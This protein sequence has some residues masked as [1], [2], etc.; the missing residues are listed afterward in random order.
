MA[1]AGPLALTIVLG[2][3]TPARAADAA[4]EEASRAARDQGVHYLRIKRY[5][6][7]L[8]RLEEAARLPGGAGDYQTQYSLAMAAYKLLVLEKAFPAARRAVELAEGARAEKASQRLLQRMDDFFGGVTLTQAPDQV[9]QVEKGLV[10]LEDTGGLINKEK[11]ESFARIR[12]RFKATPVELPLTIYLPFGKYTANL[13]P[14]ETKNGE[15]AD[16]V[17]FLYVP[18]NEGGISP[19]WYIGGGVAAAAIATTATVL[20]MDTD[21]PERQVQ[22]R[23]VQLTTPGE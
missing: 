21:P 2:A 12:D 10:H 6:L 16:A 22:I 4:E 3:A 20:L 13:A 8:G 23:S 11:K 15:T 17:M 18:D 7:A 19:W 14:F 1:G 9:G 5:E